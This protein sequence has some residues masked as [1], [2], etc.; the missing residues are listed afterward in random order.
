MILVLFVLSLL[1]FATVCHKQRIQSSPYLL[2][3]ALSSPFCLVVL[4][5]MM[6]IDGDGRRKLD[7][8]CLRTLQD[9]LCYT[10]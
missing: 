2:V 4:M 7:C 5:V 6:M 8:S 9:L 1:P 10:T 3:V